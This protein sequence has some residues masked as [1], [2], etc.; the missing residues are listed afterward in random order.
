[1]ILDDLASIAP[2][3][4]RGIK[5]HATAEPFNG[6]GQFGP[7][8]YLLVRP[9]ISWSWGSEGEPFRDG[10][11]TPHKTIWSGREA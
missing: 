3:K 9:R 1:L 8:D 2:W 10:T 5:I 7:G 11:F 6:E 4:P